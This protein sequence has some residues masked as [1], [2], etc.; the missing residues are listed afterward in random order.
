MSSLVMEKDVV[1]CHAPDLGGEGRHHYLHA[2]DRAPSEGSGGH[3][4]FWNGLEKIT[5]LA[6]LQLIGMQ[7]RK[8]SLCRGGLANEVQKLLH[9][10]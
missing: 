6:A 5:N 9:S 1:Q 4:E 2:G 8:E 3:L 7:V 10:C